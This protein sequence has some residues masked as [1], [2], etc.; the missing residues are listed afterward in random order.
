MHYL[1]STSKP[2]PTTRRPWNKLPIHPPTH[3]LII[4]VLLKSQT[5][6]WKL[7]QSVLCG[8]VYITI[9][10]TQHSSPQIKFSIVFWKAFSR[11]IHWLSEKDF[12]SRFWIDAMTKKVNR[13]S[14]FQFRKN[15]Q[16][17]YRNEH[18]HAIH[19]R[20][21]IV[22][23]AMAAVREAFIHPKAAFPEQFN[24]NL[25]IF[26]WNEILFIWKHLM[27]NLNARLYTRIDC[28]RTAD[29]GN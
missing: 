17:F 5:L 24:T 2:S 7:F 21:W 20:G 3:P 1:P 26:D 14:K 15:Q 16:D 29:G 18:I 10:I 23:S 6:F 19:T 13:K 12:A 8:Q 9:Q 22:A 25:F 28:R 11:R 27:W 4:S